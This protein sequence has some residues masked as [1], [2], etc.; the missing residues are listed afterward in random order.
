MVS[1]E[2]A[3]ENQKVEEGEEIVPMNFFISSVRR[4][5]AK[6]RRW[7]SSLA[8]RFVPAKNQKSTSIDKTER[9][10]L[11]LYLLLSRRQFMSDKTS[12]FGYSGLRQMGALF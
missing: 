1:F 11:D 7:H 5:E 8:K 4:I 12:K 3:S 2:K 9:N 6:N 10:F